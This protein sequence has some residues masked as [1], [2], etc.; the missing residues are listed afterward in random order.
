MYLSRRFGIITELKELMSLNRKLSR[1]TEPSMRLYF[2]ILVIFAIATV[3][4]NYY[5]AAG[6]LVVILFLFIY[7]RI[8]ARK[9]RMQMLDYMESVSFELDTAT[10][11]TLVNFPLP[12]VIFRMADSEI[13]WSNQSFLKISGE[14]EHL[15]ESRITDV[16]PGFSARWLLEGQNAAPELVE[17]R[18][19]KFRVYG[20]LARAVD[21]SRNSGM[22][23]TTYWFDVTDLSDIRDEYL[24]SRPV[25]GIIMLDNYD[26]LF[27]NVTDAVKSSALAQIDDRINQ[28]AGGIGGFLNKYDRDRYAFVFEE[29]YLKKFV[30][31]KFSLLDSV[32][33]VEVP[34]SIHPTVSIGLGKDGGSLEEN[35]KY[36]AMSIDMALSRGG[37]QAVI[38]NR[39]NFEFFG[40]KTA[41]MEKR[42]KVKSRVMANALG[43]LIS[44]SSGV[45]IM[46][47]AFSDFD[48]LGAAAGVCC[49]ARKKGKP[50]RIVVNPEKNAAMP[51]INSLLRLP[52]Y[53]RAFITPQ[54]AMLEIDGKSLL[55]VVDTNRPEQ[56]ESRDFLESV[57][58]VAVIDHHRRAQTHIENAALNFHEPYASSAS[59]LVTELLQYL[60]DTG[61]LL[62]AEAEAL[63]AGIVLDTKNFSL[64]TGG[65]T[66]EAAA[67]LRRAGADTTEVK[68]LLQS[69]L[70]SAVERYNI[71]S[72]ARM[73]REGIAVALH[74]QYADRAIAAQAADELLNINGIEASFVV[75][76]DGEGVVGISG[77]SIGEVNVQVILEKLGGGGNKATAGAQVRDQTPRE[78]F[79]RL[80]RVIDEY[81]SDEGK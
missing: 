59:E 36:A 43:E 66:F 38:K 45:Y 76:I 79:A 46:G 81:L 78:V 51:L 50:A 7:S 73:Y 19:R 27:K 47:H 18:G 21:Q 8:S 42:T 34:G 24:N 80:L 14:R 17:L 74:E 15:F 62:R 56:T 53:E 44:D 23:C 49:I 60:T 63:L 10:K 58:R 52:E 68:K 32:R 16:L 48:C 12:M 69:D 55:V 1:L 70:K 75:Y 71:V 39:M 67:Y 64:R 5:L 2:I 30:D 61:D 25:M 77:R 9:R 57:G 40:G 3:F 20:N 6:E 72:R 13:L 26:E 41:E 35:F 4:F 33:E 28:W 22:V 65:R 29:R 11:D 37:D 31:G 54:D